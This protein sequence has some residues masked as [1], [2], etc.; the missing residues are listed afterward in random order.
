MSSYLCDG[1]I[2]RLD[3]SYHLWFFIV[4]DLGASR[5]RRPWPALDC[6]PQ[7]GEFHHQCCLAMIFHV[8]VAR[9]R[10][11]MCTRAES[12]Y[13]LPY[14]GKW[15]ASRPGLLNP[16]VHHPE[17]VEWEPAW[18]LEKREKPL[19]PVGSRTTISRLHCTVIYLSDRY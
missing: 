1:P 9:V 11:I 7:V 14:G 13:T 6:A 15:S 19:G 3:E 8:P 5:M 10:L 17:P 2:P 12:R 16:R 4:C 18:G